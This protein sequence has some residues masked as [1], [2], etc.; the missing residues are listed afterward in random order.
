MRHSDHR[1]SGVS[2]RDWEVL[3]EKLVTAGFQDLKK[4]TMGLP[5]GRWPKH[6]IM[7]DAGLAMLCIVEDII[8]Q[9]RESVEQGAR[10]ETIPARQVRTL[11]AYGMNLE[12]E[13]HSRGW[14]LHVSVVRM[15]AQKPAVNYRS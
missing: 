10:D 12:E 11:R 4:D 15:W 2:T 5:I 8:R 7:K 9:F 6:P 13:L 14:N 1:V 3:Q